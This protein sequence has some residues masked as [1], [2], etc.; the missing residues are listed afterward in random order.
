MT[1]TNIGFRSLALGILFAFGWESAAWGGGWS[2]Q[3]AAFRV[4]ARAGDG[5]ALEAKEAEWAVWDAAWTGGAERVEVTLERPGGA[6][7]TLGGGEGGASRGSAEWA[8]GAD[9]WGTFTLRLASW[10]A[11]GEPLE[12]RLALRIRRAPAERAY[13][14]WIED[15]GG[16]PEAMP[17][18]ADADADGASN[19]EE[20]IADTDPLDAEETF[21]SRL[22]TREDGTLRVVPTVIS[23]GR[24]YRAKLHGDLLRDAVWHDLGPGRPGIGAPLGD[25]TAPQGYGA[26]GVSLP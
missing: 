15:R 17:M 20:Y 7:E 21:A 26:V 6:V 16:T 12:E 22:E 4:D 13:A 2:G 8:P 23:T 25:A 3:T 9:E 5:A 11:D 10:N 14:A 24:V 1:A 19:W 18:A